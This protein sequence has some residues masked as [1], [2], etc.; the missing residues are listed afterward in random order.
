MEQQA[1][2]ALEQALNELSAENMHNIRSTIEMCFIACGKVFDDL[3][4][5]WR[6]NQNA[7]ASRDSYIIFIPKA[8]EDQINA[9]MNQWR[10]RFKDAINEPKPVR[11]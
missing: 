7:I 4:V 2:M 1:P 5:E 9:E 10:T 11:V 8:R 6:D 3:L